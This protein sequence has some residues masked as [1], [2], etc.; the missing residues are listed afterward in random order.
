[1]HSFYH[2]YYSSCCDFWL[3]HDE[4]LQFVRLIG[5]TNQARATDYI[6]LCDLQ[7]D[8]QH[9]QISDPPFKRAWILSDSDLTACIQ[10]FS[11]VLHSERTHVSISRFSFLSTVNN[12]VIILGVLTFALQ[13]CLLLFLMRR[14]WQ[15]DN[16]IKAALKSPDSVNKPS[17]EHF[18]LYCLPSRLEFVISW[19]N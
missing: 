16:R 13:L 12:T 2:Q 5:Q 6:L 3:G 15:L 17:G 10:F 8:F 11:A 1:M 14:C 19:I 18:I 7:H 9:V 4:I